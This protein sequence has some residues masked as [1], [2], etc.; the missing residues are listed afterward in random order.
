MCEK[1]GENRVGVDVSTSGE[2]EAS[3]IAKE[4][5]EGISVMQGLLVFLPKFWVAFWQ[6]VDKFFSGGFIWCVGD[7]LVTSSEKLLLLKFDSFPRWVAKHDIKTDV[8]GEW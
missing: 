7:F 6:L 2:W 8:G 5:A 3:A 1:F 4:F